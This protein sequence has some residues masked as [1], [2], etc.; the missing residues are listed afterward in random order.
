MNST[1]FNHQPPKRNEEFD[2]GMRSFAHRAQKQS[3]GFS[4]KPSRPLRRKML[5]FGAIGWTV[6]VPTV[7]GAALGLW[8]DTL[9]PSYYSWFSMLLPIGLLVGCMTAVLWSWQD[10]A[11]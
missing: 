8:V 6:A 1:I 3:C 4:N 2:S 5:T 9:W 11:P 10:N 7:L